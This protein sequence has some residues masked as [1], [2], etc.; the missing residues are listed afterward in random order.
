MKSRLL[1]VPFISLCCSIASAVPYDGAQV[2]LNQ[3][4]LDGGFGIGNQLKHSVLDYLEE[5]KKGI[6]KGKANMQKWM[7]AGKEYIKQDNLLCELFR[8]SNN[9]LN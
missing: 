3:T 4:P 5:S 1:L 9:C 8:C 2:V 7:H 6:L